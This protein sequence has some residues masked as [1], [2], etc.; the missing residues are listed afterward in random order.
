MN[1]TSNIL[2]ISIIALILSCSNKKNTKKVKH[3]KT[4]LIT[5]NTA[6]PE[7]IDKTERIILERVSNNEIWIYNCYKGSFA[8][9]RTLIKVNKDLKIKAAYYEYWTDNLELDYNYS[10]IKSNITFNKNPF[11]NSQGVKVKYVLN[12]KEIISNTDTN[13]KTELIKT[14]KQNLFTK[15][16]N[17]TDL[18]AYKKKHNFINQYNAY[19]Y[20]LIDTKPKLTSNIDIFKKKLNHKPLFLS[21]SIDET[22]TVFKKSIKIRFLEKKLN[23]EKLIKLITESLKFSAGKINNTTV[24]VEMTYKL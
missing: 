19:P 24:N 9:S 5:N 22:G 12:V 10:I 6:L 15:E 14:I 18:D 13:N 16:I 3:A 8:G 2:F 23:K 21:F 4:V 7:E 1:R 11:T 20:F 17:K